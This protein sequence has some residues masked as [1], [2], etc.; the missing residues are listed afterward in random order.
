MKQQELENIIIF[1]FSHIFIITNKRKV[2]NRKLSLILYILYIYMYIYI[3]I[4]IL[5][6]D[7]YSFKRSRSF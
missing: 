5:F 4:Y 2:T 3:I 1:I 7:L 6:P